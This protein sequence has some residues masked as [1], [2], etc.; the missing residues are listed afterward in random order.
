MEE[1]RCVS[2]IHYFEQVRDGQLQQVRFMV[3]NDIIDDNNIVAVNGEELISLRISDLV[4]AMSSV[5]EGH[6]ETAA[7]SI[8]LY[9][10]KPTG[11]QEAEAGYRCGRG[12]SLEIGAE[13]DGNAVCIQFL[14]I[15]PDVVFTPW[16]SYRDDTE[17]KIK[18]WSGETATSTQNALNITSAMSSKFAKDHVPR[19]GLP[20]YEP[21]ENLDTSDPTKTTLQSAFS[22]RGLIAL[23]AIGLL[24]GAG[25]YHYWHQ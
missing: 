17:P 3:G 11:S 9:R 10:F 25:I 13:L 20:L 2:H 22:A 18:L 12:D 23:V 1:M 8:H 5:F 16:N 4:E 15:S 7:R 24:M 21:E 19:T 14:E 6:R